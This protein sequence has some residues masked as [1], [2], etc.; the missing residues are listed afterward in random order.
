MRVARPVSDLDT[1]QKMYCKG[2]DMQVLGQFLDHQGFDGVMIG[3]PSMQY[4]FEF[5]RCRHHQVIPSPT[6]EDIVV[7]YE[8]D[9]VQWVVRCEQLL[10][11]GF[12]QVESFNPY[13]DAHGKTF[14]DLDGYRIV[15]QNDEWSNT[16]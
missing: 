14:Q 8:P 16:A 10:S 9:N 12:I 7:F 11:A 2:L 1:T 5:T 6:P 15:I 13:W 4:H 3:S